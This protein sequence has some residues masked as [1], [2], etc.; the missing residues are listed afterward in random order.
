MPDIYAYLDYRKFL[1]DFY[2][3]N[4]LKSHKFSFQSFARKANI[5]S[6]GFLLHVMKGER[7]LTRPVMLSV[8]KAMK[9]TSSQTDY[10]ENLVLFGQARN[11]Q[12][13]DRSYIKILESRQA[14]NLKAI[15]DS[16]YEFYSAWFHAVIREI[17]GIVKNKV[18]AMELAKL[19]VPA[20]TTSEA[21][22]SLQLL[23]E[24][25]L[26]RKTADGGY[27][28]TEPFF[29]GGSPLLRNMA[30]VQ[31]QKAML[32]K[33]AQAWDY[34]KEK[35]IDMHTVT[36]SISD[37]AEKI[38]RDEIGAF[39]SKLLNVIQMDAEKATRAYNININFFPVS[40]TIQERAI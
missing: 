16:Q 33:A 30:I 20:I 19:I 37:S 29:S 5:A 11:Q 25:N 38:I 36:F 14:M 35:E 17:A 10:F 9:L 28:Q 13:K 22:H 18:S 4:K 40:K 21:K 3:E 27:E 7:N 23:E 6:S 15:D 32:D 31:F 34:F 39:K 8:A 24:L 2:E 12:E 26:L 1:R